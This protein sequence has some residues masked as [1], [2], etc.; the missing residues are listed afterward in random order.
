ME[1]FNAKGMLVSVVDKYSTEV[2]R[3]NYNANTGV[4]TNIIYR[5]SKNIQLSYTSG[6]LLAVTYSN[7][8]CTTRLARFADYMEVRHYSGETIKLQQSTSSDGPEFFASLTSVNNKTEIC[9]NEN[10][11]TISDY[12][13][14]VIVNTTTYAIGY[15]SV[16]V[17]N[18]EGVKTRMQYQNSQLICSYEVDEEEDVNL[19]NG[20]YGGSVQINKT[21]ENNEDGVSGTVI[22]YRRGLDGHTEENNVHTFSVTQY[23]SSNTPG[24]FILTGWMKKIEEVG[25][26]GTSAGDATITIE[27]DNNRNEVSFCPNIPSNGKW[28]FFTYAFYANV[29][30]LP[31]KLPTSSSISVKDLR[32]SH[33]SINENS[34]L[35]Y[36][37]F[38]SPEYILIYTGTS[39][40]KIPISEAHFIYQYTVNGVTNRQPI[41]PTNEVCFEDLL[42]YKI[43]KKK[44][45]SSTRYMRTEVKQLLAQIRKAYY[46]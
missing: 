16:E 23:A 14:N 38:Q 44:I 27:I 36:F 46:F 9:R 39:D 37:K 8:G 29:T 32:L 3:L 25:S 35:N 5:N 12:I 20:M 4:L 28:K 26:D 41:T 2:V 33:E 30:D 6:K 10:V 7:A 31:I 22:N 42:R 17:T 18:N 43:N 34:D 24:R 19:D 40:L 1:Y 11:F 13:N 15:N 45:Y 21:M